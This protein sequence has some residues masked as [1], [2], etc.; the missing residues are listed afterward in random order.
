MS[1]RAIGNGTSCP[2]VGPAPGGAIIVRNI[3]KRPTASR[4]LISIAR[5]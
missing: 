4:R 2:S 3:A 5:R 1:E